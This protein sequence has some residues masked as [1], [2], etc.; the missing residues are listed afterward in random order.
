MKLIEKSLLFLLPFGAVMVVITMQAGSVR[1]QQ[2][3]AADKMTLACRS[4]CLS[5]RELR[6]RDD[7]IA[8]HP[9]EALTKTIYDHPSGDDGQQPDAGRFG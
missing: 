4:I 5:P 8:F 2:A 6:H 7:K 9:V 3:S 1:A